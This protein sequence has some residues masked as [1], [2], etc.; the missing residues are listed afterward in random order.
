MGEKLTPKVG[1]RVVFVGQGKTLAGNIENITDYTTESFARVRV[2][3]HEA[4]WSVRTT[5]LEVRDREPVEWPDM[6]SWEYGDTSW[7]RNRRLRSPEGWNVQPT[8]L[9]SCVFVDANAIN[10]ADARQIADGWNHV[11]DHWDELVG[12]GWEAYA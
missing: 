4:P 7:E 8:V 12:D 11:A 6:P 9:G 5:D 2:D 10:P 1:D 3:G